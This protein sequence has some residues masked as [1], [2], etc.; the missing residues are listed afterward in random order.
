VRRRG[1]FLTRERGSILELLFGVLERSDIAGQTRPSAATATDDPGL[2]E[3]VAGLLAGS[4][5]ASAVAAGTDA[6][7]APPRGSLRA[8]R[9]S[10]EYKTKPA[11]VGRTDS[12]GLLY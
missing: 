5:D 6:I 9:L 3:L 1:R 4:R 8:A 12:D 10:S 11:G 2:R 7:S